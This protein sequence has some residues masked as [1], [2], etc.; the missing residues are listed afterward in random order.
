M[1][2]GV[3]P[4]KLLPGRKYSPGAIEGDPEPHKGSFLLKCGIKD[5]QGILV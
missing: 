1:S 4:G 2:S 3:Y 5:A